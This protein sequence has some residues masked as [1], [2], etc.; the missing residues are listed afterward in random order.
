MQQSHD[1]LIQVN[2]TLYKLTD[3]GVTSFVDNNFCSVIESHEHAPCYL[4]CD[5]LVEFER[6]LYCDFRSIVMMRIDYVHVHFLDSGVS[7]VV[8]SSYTI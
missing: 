3:I 8:T 7:D 6:S 2:H 1:A 4:D 5:T